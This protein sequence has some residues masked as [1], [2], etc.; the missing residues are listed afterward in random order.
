MQELWEKLSLTPHC[1]LKKKTK[2]KNQPKTCKAFWTDSKWPSMI[3]LGMRFETLCIKAEF[4]Y[5][6]HINTC[7]KT[8]VFPSRARN[9]DWNTIVLKLLLLVFSK[10]ELRHYDCFCFWC[11]A[12]F[13]LWELCS[14]E[15]H[16]HFSRDCY[17]L[18]EKINIEMLLVLIQ[19]KMFHVE[20]VCLL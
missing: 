11:A 2:Q 18:Q 20:V 5:H 1:V 13:C 9:L 3:L 19:L 6:A 17:S 12:S 4:E 15:I 14:A 10:C 8:L 7:C 16:S